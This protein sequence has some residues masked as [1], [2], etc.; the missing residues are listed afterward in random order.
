ML[1]PDDELTRPETLELFGKFPVP[2]G[3]LTP[4]E[5]DVG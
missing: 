4:D 5:F 3:E 2:V 1:Q